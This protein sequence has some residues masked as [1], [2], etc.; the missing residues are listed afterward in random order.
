MD[1]EDAKTPERRPASTRIKG[2][3]EF[4]P[5]PGRK[6]AMQA[7]SVAMIPMKATAAAKIPMKA[8]G[9]SKKIPMKTTPAKSCK[10]VGKTSRILAA[11]FN[12]K[13]VRHKNVPA[14][15]CTKK[16]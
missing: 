8:N 6:F 11:D 5:H 1:D 14:Q 10:K 12:L 9:V 4:M 7:K 3:N 15:L 2:K 16:R 13:I